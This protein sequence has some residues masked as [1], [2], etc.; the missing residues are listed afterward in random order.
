MGGC[1]LFGAW[2]TGIRWRCDHREDFIKNAEAP[3]SSLPLEQFCWSCGLFLKH[4]STLTRIPSRAHAHTHLP[5]H[6]QKHAHP[7]ALHI[8]I[9]VY[10]H[11]HPYTQTHTH[12]HTSSLIMSSSAS[13][14]S[15]LCKSADFTHE[16]C[17][18]VAHAA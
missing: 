18:I 13:K 15:W 2:V 12:T 3:A 5:R 16:T 11:R 6:T 4:P 9:S 8:Q 1:C 10:T 14:A 7:S 17:I